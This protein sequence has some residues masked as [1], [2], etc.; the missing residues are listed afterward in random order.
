MPQKPNRAGNMQNYVP[1][2]NGDASGEYGDN[3]SGSNKNFATQNNT[4]TQSAQPKQTTTP[5]SSTQSKQNQNQNPPKQSNPQQNSQPTPTSDVKVDLL[6]PSGK[7]YN[8]YTQMDSNQLRQFYR[9]L[10]Q[11]KELNQQVTDLGLNGNHLQRVISG[12]GLNK[13]PKV[14]SETDF[15]NLIQSD[16]TLIPLY[17]GVATGTGMTAQQVANQ[18]MKGNDTRIG[19]GIHGDGIYFTTNYNYADQ[20]QRQGQPM[21]AC[22]DTTKLKSITEADLDRMIANE[23]DSWL[24]NASRDDTDKAV[25]ALQKGYNCIIARGGNGS[26]PYNKKAKKGEDYY[27]FL[28]REPIIFRK[29]PKKFANY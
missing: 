23:Q 18:T 7:T 6:T 9:D 10:S 3:A 13:K 20:Y 24:Q 5:P 21:T 11:N 28:T 8:E 29:T 1:A 16:D 17:R 22:V 14:L 26:T 12:L 2:G 4:N 15:D 25:Y 27:V 19:T